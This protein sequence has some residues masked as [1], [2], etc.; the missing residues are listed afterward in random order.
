[1]R[2]VVICAAAL[3]LTLPQ[4]ATGRDF[5][6]PIEF[7]S[8]AAPPTFPLICEWLQRIA[9]QLDPSAT[10]VEIGRQAVLAGI[11]TLDNRT[12]ARLQLDTLAEPILRNISATTCRF[13]PSLKPLQWHAWKRAMEA[14]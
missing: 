5:P 14:T 3:A 13:D 9:Q 6:V 4:P 1:M 12:L 8:G 11:R 2:W 7:P 10:S